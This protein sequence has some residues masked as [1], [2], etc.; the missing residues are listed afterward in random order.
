VRGEAVMQTFPT[1]FSSE[2]APSGEAFAPLPHRL[3]LDPS[4]VE[5]GKRLFDDARLSLDGHAACSSCHLLDRGGANGMARSD[6]P[7]RPPVPVNV[8]SIF[9]AAFS[10]RFGWSGRFR[11]IGEQLDFAMESRAAM[12]S[13]WEYAA[14]AVAHDAGYR[15]A[16]VR[17]YGR[18]P[19]AA[20]I[21][22]AVAL[23]SLSLLTPDSRFDRHLRGEL[24]LSQLEQR[25]YELFR[26][27]GCASC[28]QGISLGGNMLQRFGVMRDYF[29]ERTALTPADLGLFSLTRRAEDRYV[30]RVPS[31]RN[32]A[33]TAPYFHDASAK[34]LDEAVQIMAEYQLGRD[35]KDDERRALIAFLE[36][37]TGELDGK[38]L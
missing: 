24:T 12:A 33:L 34:T 5:L 15:D 1:P 28:H 21:R 17:S 29:A 25:G 9:N 38:P 13:N 20:S 7:G 4:K 3:A 10:F 35:L 8:P 30:F 22:E 37:L 23:Y 32:V 16:F 31:L 19:T 18:G 2:A 36:T 14:R 26:D 6:L 27:Y 11:D